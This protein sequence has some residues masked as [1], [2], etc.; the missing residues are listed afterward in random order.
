MKSLLLLSAALFSASA[1]FSED[2]V[3][4]APS[5]SGATTIYRQLMPDGRVIYS[6]K[7]EKGGKLDH[8]ITVEP[9]IKGNLWTTEA[10]AKPVIPPQI[11]H[12]TVNRVSVIP[13]PGKKKTVEEAGLEV[14]R[15]EMLLEDAKKKQEA[16]VEPLPGERTTDSAGSA[17]V[18]EAYEA[19]QKLLAREV[20][21]AEA[22]LKKSIADRN[23]LR[24]E[25]H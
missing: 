13:V 20:F 16:G 25:K 11:E 6:D 18:S 22:A 17:Q 7:A 19:R 14:I 4:P 15:A 9:P 8:T 1:A 2:I 3:A 23:A 24:F 21:Y 5:G 12:T 10:A